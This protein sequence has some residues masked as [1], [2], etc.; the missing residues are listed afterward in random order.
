VRIIDESVFEERHQRDADLAPLLQRE[1]DLL[2]RMM[3]RGSVA[4]D[5]PIDLQ[6][7]PDR[8]DAKQ[9]W[10]LTLR[11]VDVVLCALPA[12]AD[13]I[14]AATTRFANLLRSGDLGN[15]LGTSLFET[16]PGGTRRLMKRTTQIEPIR[17]DQAVHRETIAAE[18]HAEGTPLNEDEID[19]AICALTALAS[20]ADRLEGPSLNAELES[21]FQ[22]HAIVRRDL[23]R[24]YVILKAIPFEN[25]AVSRVS[26]ETWLATP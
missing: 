18:W 16:Y 25:V 13:K 15:R 14:G 9:I 5:V 12:L 23:P 19:A 3:A 2:C 4:V 26:Y 6:R 20:G 24:G 21:E 7:L 22:R 11:P 10:E 8:V 1:V 17:R